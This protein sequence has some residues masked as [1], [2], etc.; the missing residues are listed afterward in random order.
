MLA[1]FLSCVTRAFQRGIICEALSLLRLTTTFATAWFFC[2]KAGN[3]LGIPGFIGSIS[4]F[5]LLVFIGYL[6][7]GRLIQL[8]APENVPSITSKLLGALT[9]AFEGIILAWILFFFMASLP[10][11]KVP[12]IPAAA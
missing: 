4:G 11:S 1:I 8:I 3:L 6:I 5:Y 2:D 7:F 9:G 10:G 12:G